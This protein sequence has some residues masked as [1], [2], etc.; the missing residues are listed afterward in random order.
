MNQ[1]GGKKSDGDTRR[2]RAGSKTNTAWG[3]HGGGRGDTILMHKH[4]TSPC[5]Q[6]HKQTNEERRNQW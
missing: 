3:I 1:V 2:M 6:I 4:V 5:D